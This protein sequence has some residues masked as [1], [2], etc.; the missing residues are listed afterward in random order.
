MNIL[1]RLS[2]STWGS[3]MDVLNKIYTTYIKPLLKYVCEILSL[4]N[5]KNM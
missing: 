3:N 2:G 4:T 5:K 1:K